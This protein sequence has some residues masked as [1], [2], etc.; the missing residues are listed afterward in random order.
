MKKIL[1][2]DNFKRLNEAYEEDPEYRI[3]KYF[4]GLE[5]DIKKWFEEGVF[6]LDNVQL[7]DIKIN[8]TNNLDKYL[9]FD[10][11]DSY[12]YYQIMFIISL[13]EVTEDTLKECFIKVKRYDI[14]TSEL[15]KQKEESIMVED[16]TGDIIAEMI[17]NLDT[18]ESEESEE[19][20]EESEDT[21][22]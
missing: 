22:F 15:L 9:T 3:K 20:E 6:S 19:S 18:E 1:K 17:A 5:K 2:F 11:Q 10:F 4:D 8:T 16:L 21:N 7:Y 14:E 13:Q 12:Y